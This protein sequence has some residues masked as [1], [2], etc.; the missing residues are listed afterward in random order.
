MARPEQ[1]EKPTPKRRHEA[2]QRGQVPRSSD[3]ST[4]FIF[5][6]AVVVIHIAFLTWVSSVEGMFRVT[7]THLGTDPNVTPI[8]AWGIFARAFNML[9]PLLLVILLISGVI[10]YVA[11][12]LQ[13]GFLFTGYPLVPKFSKLNPITGAQTVLFSRQTVVNLAKQLL[14]LGAVVVII[15]MSIKDHLPMVYESARVSPHQWMTAVEGLAFTVALRFGIFLAVLALLDYAF[16]RYTL[17]QSLKMSR[18]EVKDEMRQSE[19]NPEVRQHVRQRQRAAARRRMMAAVPRATVVV[20][21][22][23][24]FACALEWDE[25]KMDA[26]LL[27]AKGADLLAKRI[28]DLAKEHKI[29]I[30]ENPTLARTLYQKVELDSPVPPEL[31]AATAQVIAFVYKLKRKTLAS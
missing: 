6:A 24:H 7:L 3:V 9:L 31:Y 30:V 29:P 15:F 12:V 20:T 27:T 28:R 14:K 4:S 19:G 8:S 5:I 11:N 23:T 22:P 26:P 25:V 13:F 1:T 21:N 16:Q 18:T 2:R 17:E 10:A